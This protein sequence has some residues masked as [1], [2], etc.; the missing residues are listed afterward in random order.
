MLKATPLCV[1]RQVLRVLIG[2]NLP[3]VLWTAYAILQATTGGFGMGGCPV[4]SVLGWCPGCGLTRAYSV[5]LETGS[6][7][8]WLG[9]ILMAFLL[10][11]AWSVYIAVRVYAKESEQCGPKIH[12]AQGRNDLGVGGRYGS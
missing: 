3:V 5:F 6:C 2:H 4:H 7:S 11:A 9:F 10:N 12:L 1:N 8:P